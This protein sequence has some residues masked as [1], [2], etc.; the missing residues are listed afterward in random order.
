M[1]RKG[2]NIYKRKDGRWEARVYY[3]RTT[4][5]RSVYGKS[6]K[7]ALD[8]QY[9]LRRS[10][11]V[12]EHTDILFMT[13]VEQWYAE[14]CLYIK[15]SSIASYRMRIRGHIKPYFGS[16]FYSEVDLPMI[17]TFVRQKYAEGLSYRYIGT[18]VMIIKSAAE[19]AAD[20]YGYK[21][22]IKKFKLPPQRTSEP[23]LLTEDE[24][25]CLRSYLAKQEDD[26]SF[27][28]LLAM[29]TGLRIGELCALKWSDIDGKSG[30]MKITK[31][32][33]RIAVSENGSCAKTALVTDPP[34]TKT[35]ARVIPLPRFL[36]KAAETHRRGE[37]CFLL[38]G[39]ETPI[40]PRRLTYCFKKLLDG[41][42]L[43]DVKFH[44]LRH[45]FATNCLRLNFDI[46]TLSEILGHSGANITMRVYLHSSSEQKRTCMEKLKK[47]T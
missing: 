26:I 16:V 46:K 22:N 27:G 41:L 6:Y 25:S 38:S 37:N 30:E 18:M 19:R 10:M 11:G 24:Q 2:R 34:K 29:F 1:P 43:P 40:E 3:K 5:Y 39:S 32:L 44:S 28:I 45:A 4:K 7:E 17:S 8:K 33:Q 35:S 42:G 12:D 15:Q 47:L 21:N 31:T 20:I 36:L 14:K 23:K 13:A 9:A